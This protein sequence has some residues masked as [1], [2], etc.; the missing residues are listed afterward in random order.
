[1]HDSKYDNYAKWKD[2]N[3]FFQPSKQESTL[4]QKEFKHVSF[5]GK[6]I[7]D[8]GFGSGSLLAWARQQGAEIVGVE[9]QSDLLLEAQKIGVDT[10]TSLNAIPDNSFDIVT[11]FD[12]LEHV[13]INEIPNML[14]QVLRLCN[15]G[16]LVFFRFPNCQSPAGLASQFGDPTHITMLSGPLLEIMLGSAGFKEIKY[17]EAVMI[18]SKKPLQN[19]AKIIL[20]PVQWLFILAYR[21]TWSIGTAPL[22]PNVIV[23]A[24]K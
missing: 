13:S 15:D 19:W 9:I 7:L 8:I 18:A 11:A 24:K 22:T 2:W 3:Q 16:A 14:Q 4:F 5:V 21:L 6:K 1:M 23:Q 17:K 12:V 20:K 10:Y